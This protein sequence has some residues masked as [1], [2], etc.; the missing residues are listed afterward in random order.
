MKKFILSMVLA[1]AAMP[2]L[3]QPPMVDPNKQDQ[4]LTKAE[5][6][7]RITEFTNRT[8]ALQSEL[9]ALNTEVGNLNSKMTQLANDAQKCRDAIY[10]LVGATE[11]D[12]RN[13][14]ERLGRIE[15]RVREIGGMGDDRLPAMRGELDSLERQLNGMRGEKI[16]VLPEFY[17]KII[18]IAKQINDIRGRMKTSTYTVGTWA[19]DRDCLWNIAGKETIYNDPFMWPKIWQAN[20]EQIRNP[21]I[22]YPGQVLNIPPAGP[23]NDAELK[24]ER[25]YYRRHHMAT[26]RVAT[27]RTQQVDQQDAGSGA[28]R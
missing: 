13:F 1:L 10:A 19:K 23:K 17:N 24:A 9:D 12:V 26:R 6:E 22:I 4:D 16:A 5:A 20:T 15:N 8:N 14:R 3:A 27:E 28:R 18:D 21:D 2:A 7:V 11:A 25:L